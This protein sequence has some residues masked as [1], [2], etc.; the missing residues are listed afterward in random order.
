[1]ECLLSQNILSGIVVPEQQNDS[2]TLLQRLS[3][4]HNIP[5][6]VA[7]RKKDLIRLS[8]WAPLAEA[9]AML[10]FSFPWLIPHSVITVPRLGSYNFHTGIV[11]TYRG[12]EPVFWTLFN[13]ERQTAISVLE[14]D[15][16][17]DTGHVMLST[18]FPIV[19]EDTY[20]MM[21]NKYATAGRTA[22]ETLLDKLRSDTPIHGTAQPT[23]Y[24]PLQHRPDADELTIHWKSQQTEQIHNL[25]RAANP[26]FD[27]AMVVLRNIHFRILEAA[28]LAR[29]SS[30]KVMPG[31]ILGVNEP[32][33]FTVA[34][35]DGALRIN[36]IRSQEGIFTGSRFAA[37]YGIQRGELFSM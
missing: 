9:D 17:L 6:H 34:C 20:G 19:A 21:L 25:I 1:M 27:G 31:T 28:I 37:L 2:V 22:M 29:P 14:M 8:K 15:H 30:T 10:V 3:V 4:R 23:G 26:A 5:L 35:Q 24:F 13:G 33:G 7:P 32:D 16:D 36:I 11:P 12:I 18:P